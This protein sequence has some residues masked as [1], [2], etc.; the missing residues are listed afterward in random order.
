MMKW[1]FAFNHFNYA[2]WGSVHLYDLMT[3]HSLCPNVH[4]DF[5]NGKL[6]GTEVAPLIDVFESD[7]YDEPCGKPK[8]TTRIQKRF[9]IGSCQN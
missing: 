7:L 5:M 8:N 9:K 4:A 3:V 6:S 1:F 2:C